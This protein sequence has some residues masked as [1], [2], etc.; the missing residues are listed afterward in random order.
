MHVNNSPNSVLFLVE[1]ELQITV[2][3]LFFSFG[4]CAFVIKN[5]VN[6]T[7]NRYFAK[8]IVLDFVPF[9]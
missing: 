1:K 4:C 6:C 2:K 8:V 9:G 3:V 5:Y 7:V